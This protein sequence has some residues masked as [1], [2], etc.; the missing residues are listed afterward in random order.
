MV[1]VSE[2]R[3]L[4]KIRRRACQEQIKEGTVGG[5]DL[6]DIPREERL[7]QRV[8]FP[9]QP[10]L[11]P[12]NPDH[13]GQVRLHKEIGDCEVLVRDHAGVDMLVM[14][15]V[16]DGFRVEQHWAV[17][18]PV[19]DGEKDVDGHPHHC[20]LR[21]ERQRADLG[22]EPPDRWGPFEW[23]WLAVEHEGK[24]EAQHDLGWINHGGS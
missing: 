1:K 13:C 15:V 20:Q 9:T 23:H 4:K 6:P 3:D 12:N 18:H 7:F 2:V 24:E 22:R 5:G 19:P 21:A 17:D 14:P 16:A 10:S 8:A 11:H